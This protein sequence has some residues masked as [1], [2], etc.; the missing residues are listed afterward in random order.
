MKKTGGILL[1][2]AGCLGLFGRLIQPHNASLVGAVYWL[3]L[4][5]GTVVLLLVVGISLIILGSILN[6][7]R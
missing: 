7:D 5:S 4:M 1:I 2:I 3:A 6:R